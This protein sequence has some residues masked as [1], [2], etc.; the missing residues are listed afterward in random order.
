MENKNKSGRTS[1]LPRGS[2]KMQIEFLNICQNKDS[3]GKNLNISHS[4][5]NLLNRC[6]IIVG[7]NIW[8]I[9]I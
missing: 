6:K 7:L 4:N 8:K 5:N 9:M 2:S 3:D 1:L